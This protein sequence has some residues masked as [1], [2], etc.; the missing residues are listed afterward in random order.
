ME[1]EVRTLNLVF[2]GGVGEDAGEF[3]DLVLE[4][5]EARHLEVYP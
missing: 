5:I 3:E 2:Q 4:G 1:D